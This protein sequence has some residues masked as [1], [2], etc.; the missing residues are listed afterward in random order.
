[1]KIL[2]RLVRTP[3]LVWSGHLPS[4][5]VTSAILGLPQRLTAFACTL[6]DHGRV[7]MVRHERLGIE[8]WELPGGHVEPG[9]TVREATRRETREEAGVDVEIDRFI[10][11]GRHEWQ[12]RSVG[13]LFFLAKYR[14][15]R[16]RSEIAADLDLEPSICAVAWIDPCELTEAEVS[17]LAWPVIGMVAE[18]ETVRA[19]PLQFEATH[20]LTGA[21]WESVVT[22]AW[23][24]TTPCFRCSADR[25]HEPTPLGTS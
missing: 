2:C 5:V 8:R 20:R 18:N 3:G 14:G 12:R 22:R 19:G 10:A 15:R 24:C 1:M 13:I 11:E 9:E 6:D 25:S 17:P 16:G 4:V 21:G 23:R 7:L